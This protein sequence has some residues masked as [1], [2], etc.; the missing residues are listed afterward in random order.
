MVRM[1]VGEELIGWEGGR[2][3]SGLSLM[4]TLIKNV[5]MDTVYAG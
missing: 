3:V 5:T 4:N 1:V 2:G